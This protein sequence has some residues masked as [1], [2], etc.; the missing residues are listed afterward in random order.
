MPFWESIGICIAFLIVS[1]ISCILALS[2]IIKWGADKRRKFK[3]AD[4]I[5]Y[6]TVWATCIVCAIFAIKLGR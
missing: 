5:F 2:E 4:F 1:L 6:V 3:K